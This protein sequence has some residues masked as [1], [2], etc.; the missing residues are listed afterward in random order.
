MGDLLRFD[1][2]RLRVLVEQHLL[3]TGSARARE[4]LDDW[5]N[6]L[7]SFVKVMPLD[8]R[9]ALHRSARRTTGGK[10]RRCRLGFSHGQA[11]RIS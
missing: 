4:L 11:N 3:F 7:A 9:R 8:Y 6:A 1:A 2:E 5:D 10:G